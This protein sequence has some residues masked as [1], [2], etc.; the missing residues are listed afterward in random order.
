MTKY[1]LLIGVSRYFDASTFSQLDCCEFDAR[2]VYDR[3]ISP[4]ILGYQ[5]RNVELMHDSV[6]DHEHYKLPIE[7]QILWFLQQF[8][9]RLEQNDTFL[10]YFS[11]H[12]CVKDGEAFI[13]AKDTR[14][15]DL[16]ADGK[17]IR[18]SV[19]QQLLSE[20]RAAQ[21]IVILDACHSGSDLTKAGPALHEEEFQD[22]LQ[23]LARGMVVLSSCEKGEKSWA[24][25]KRSIFTEHLLAGLDGGAHDQEGNVTVFSLAEYVGKAV[26]NWASERKPPV[27]QTPTLLG[28]MHA[29]GFVLV[30]GQLRRPP[31]SKPSTPLAWL[32]WLGIKLSAL[33][34]LRWRRYYVAPMAAGHGN[35]MWRPVIPVRIASLDGKTFL[36]AE[37]L[38][39][40]GAGMNVVPLKLIETLSLTPSS[41]V[42][43]R[44]MGGQAQHT[45][46]YF[47]ILE[48]A[49][50]K[51]HTQ[52][53]ALDGTTPILGGEFMRQ[54]RVVLDY[55]RGRTLFRIS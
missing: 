37:A 34:F 21:K 50:A 41:M 52:V 40:S 38:L 6:P 12:G 4:R 15:E 54:H 10:L 32:P 53:A 1:A 47:V 30:C 29:Q 13:A 46:V 39:D 28:E 5:P 7:S 23:Q 11:G 44:V 36:E 14:W 2:A 55:D 45:P 49:G 16:G 33:P 25:Q 24:L 8:A 42:S 31:P 17:G 22:A 18:L 19:I 27:K 20:S 3:V 9:Q 26:A 35:N 43:L 51:I 48:I